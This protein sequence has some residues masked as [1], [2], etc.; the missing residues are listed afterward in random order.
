V[1]FGEVSIESHTGINSQ[2]IGELIFER[3]EF[4]IPA[5]I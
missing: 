4:A 5:T 1:D 2:E 3:S